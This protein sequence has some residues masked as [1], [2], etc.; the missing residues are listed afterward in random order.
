MAEP[1]AA[2]GT[3]PNALAYRSALLPLG[4]TNAGNVTWAVPQAVLSALGAAQFP[5]QV[6]RGEASVYDPTTGHVSE[7]AVGKSFDLAGTAMTGSLPFPKPAGAIGM[8]GGRNAKTA[9]LGALAKAEAL[10]GQGADRQAIWDQ[11]GWFQGRDQKWRF[12]IPDDLATLGSAGPHAPAGYGRLYHDDLA[13]AYPAMWSETQQSIRQGPQASGS[14]SA[15]D[16]LVR[17]EGPTDA[18][19]RSVALHEYQHPIQER[20]GFARGGSPEL[21]A[22]QMPSAEAMNDANVMSALIR[23]GT[24]PEEAPSAFLNML[25]RDANAVAQHLIRQHTPAEISAMPATPMDAYRRLAGEVE[26]RNVQAR[27]NMTPD[28]RR[29]TPPWLTQDVPDE[30]Q[31]VRF[32]PLGSANLT[33]PLPDTP[34]SRLGR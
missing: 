6:Y 1:L 30:Q 21:M 33:A 31:L 24:A 7:E 23:R 12:E 34:L 15:S 5:G 9:D 28:Q 29:A 8:F 18:A 11:T 32:A 16:A 25:G 2:L 26:A 3:D 4:R 19:Q 13:D 20:E 14:Y 17:A 10:V 27:A 22:E